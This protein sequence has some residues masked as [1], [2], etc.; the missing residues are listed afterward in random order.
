MQPVKRCPGRRAGLPGTESSVP[1]QQKTRGWQRP[2]R[3]LSALYSVPGTLFT[4]Q[5]FSRNATASW[6]GGPAPLAP[7]CIKSSQKW[8][9]AP[10]TLRILLWTLPEF[11]PKLILGPP[12]P[13][14]ALPGRAAASL[15]GPAGPRKRAA[16][17]QHPG[18]RSR[19]AGPRGAAYR[20]KENL[21][22]SKTGVGEGRGE[23]PTDLFIT[24]VYS[25]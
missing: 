18:R 10:L 13:C 25:S 1:T 8:G 22:W 17:R 23:R 6:S 12:P 14:T 3:A 21:P 20:G 2:L 24:L 5:N 19:A 16:E 15:A 4:R 7:I 11:N 9:G